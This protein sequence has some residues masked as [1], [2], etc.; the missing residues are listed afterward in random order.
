[1]GASLG[2]WDVVALFRCFFGSGAGG[3]FAADTSDSAA[4]RFFFVAVLAVAATADA[5]SGLSFHAAC[6]SANVGCFFGS[7]FVLVRVD[8]LTH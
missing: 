2:V 5:T 6:S 4:P 8:L 1:M 3:A 7:D